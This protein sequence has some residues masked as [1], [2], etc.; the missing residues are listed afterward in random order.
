MLTHALT[1]RNRDGTVSAEATGDLESL[2]RLMPQV[3][4]VHTEC[5]ALQLHSSYYIT[6]FDGSTITIARFAHTAEEL[7]NAD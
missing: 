2:S 6:L 7:T 3:F 4:K 5:E 1:F